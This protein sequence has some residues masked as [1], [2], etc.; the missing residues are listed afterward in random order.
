MEKYLPPDTPVKEL[1]ISE[2]LAAFATNN[3]FEHIKEMFT[4]GIHELHNYGDFNYRLQREIISLAVQNHWDDLL[5]M[6]WNFVTDV[7]PIN[8]IYV[9]NLPAWATGP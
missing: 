4:I 7:L 5:D 8:C 1:L 2:E 9:L 6:D 3:E